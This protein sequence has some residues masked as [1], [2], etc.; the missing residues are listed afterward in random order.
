M[1]HCRKS[2]SRVDLDDQQIGAAV[3]QIDREEI[4]S[5]WHPVA[6][7]IR[8]MANAA[9]FGSAAEGLA[10]GFGGLKPTLLLAAYLS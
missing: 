10:G 6:A 3:T 1:A 5:T 9:A 4:R 7:V 2:T 8:H